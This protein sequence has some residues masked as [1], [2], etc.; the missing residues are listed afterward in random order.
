MNADERRFVD[1][2]TTDRHG[3]FEQEDTEAAEPMF[4]R[5][6]FGRQ[7]NGGQGN[8][9][10]EISFVFWMQRFRAGGKSI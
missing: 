9:E 2:V 3:L 7:G 1:N 6:V 10:C 8:G 5:I 4:T